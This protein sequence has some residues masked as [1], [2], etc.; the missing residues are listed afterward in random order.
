MNQKHPI[1]PSKK[2]MEARTIAR[3]SESPCGR[4][5]LMLIEH[6]GGAPV[7]LASKLDASSDQVGQWVRHARISRWGAEQA[8]LRMGIDRHASRPDIPAGE[9]PKDHP[10][11]KP[12][13]ERGKESEDSKL[14]GRLAK[15]YGSVQQFCS[16]TGVSVHNY[17]NWKSRGR[18]PKS[19]ISAMVALDCSTQ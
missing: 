8:E 13:K 15:R 4:A 10:G 5:L 6:A 12:G 16:A 3:L 2:T 11:P 9:W 7:D 18:I 1:T 17:H 14:L 19:Q